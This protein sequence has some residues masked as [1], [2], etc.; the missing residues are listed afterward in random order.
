[1]LTANEFTAICEELLI[2]PA[3]ALENAA[4]V[5][6]LRAGLDSDAVRQILI[7]ES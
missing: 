5:A 4:V 1:M 7:D 3:I 2:H 6:A